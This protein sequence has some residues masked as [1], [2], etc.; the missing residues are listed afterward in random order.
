MWGT[1]FDA[2][3][4]VEFCFSLLFFLAS[5]KLRSETFPPT[6]YHAARFTDLT[7]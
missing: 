5:P 1:F 6:V 4:G 3:R 2:F 7:A